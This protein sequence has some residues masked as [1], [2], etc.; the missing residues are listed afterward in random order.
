M[1]FRFGPHLAL[2]SLACI[3]SIGAVG[4]G[5][6]CEK[7]IPRPQ[8]STRSNVVVTLPAS[9]ELT[10]RPYKK[11]NDDGTVTVEGLLRERDQLLGDTVSVTG[12]VDKAVLCAPIPAPPP[13]EPPPPDAPPPE[14]VVPPTCNPPQHLVLVDPG[15]AADT[16][17]RLTVYGTMKSPLKDAKEG[18][19]ISL[20][21][22]FDMVSRDGV[23]LRQGGLLLLDDLPE[24]PEPAP[25]TP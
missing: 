3:A 5:A 1:T 20:T 21:G 8:P 24:P 7:P 12:K 6:G 13:A 15:A 4:V 19:V 16:K 10:A 18:A 11:V 23:F 25:T 2:Q 9:P 22:H 14:P 17:W